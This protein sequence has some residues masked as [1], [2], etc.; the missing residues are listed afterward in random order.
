M[1]VQHVGIVVRDAEESRLFYTEGFDLVELPRPDVGIPGH[2]LADRNGVQVHLIE[3]AD[4]QVFPPGVHVAFET[5]DLDADLARLAALGVETDN[6]V[7]MIGR[8]QAFIRDP[9]GN[10][11]ELN[12][13]TA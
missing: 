5:A 8:R 6:V 9:S 12:E 7:D 2:W 1:I 13:V 10:T 11:L 4:G 3:F